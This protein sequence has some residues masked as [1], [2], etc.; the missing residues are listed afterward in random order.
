M[1]LTYEG[2][3]PLLSLSAWETMWHSMLRVEK[4]EE[5]VC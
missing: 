4:A 1:H 2:I 3:E 5:R